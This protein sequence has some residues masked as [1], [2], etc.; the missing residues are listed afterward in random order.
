MSLKNRHTNIHTHTRSP[1]AAMPGDAETGAPRERPCLPSRLSLSRPPFVLA[2]GADSTLARHIGQEPLSA[3]CRLSI[4][5]RRAVSVKSLETCENVWSNPKLVAG[6]LSRGGSGSALSVLRLDRADDLPLLSLFTS[7]SRA[8]RYGTSLTMSRPGTDDPLRVSQATGQTMRPAR[9]VG[10]MSLTLPPPMR[11]ARPAGLM[12]LTLPLPPAHTC[13]F[14]GAVAPSPHLIIFDKLGESSGRD[15]L[16][17]DRSMPKTSGSM[18]TSSLGFANL[19]RGSSRHRLPCQTP[20]ARPTS[21]WSRGSTNLTWSLNLKKQKLRQF[22]E[23]IFQRVNIRDLQLSGNEIQ[24][25]PAEIVRLEY[26]H[27]LNLDGNKLARLPT[28]LGALDCLQVLDVTGNLIADLD[29]QLLLPKNL[30][31]VRFA[32]NLLK[33]LPD[34]LFLHTKLLQVLDCK[35]NQLVQLPACDWGKELPSLQ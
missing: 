22:P 10:L 20:D 32:G 16:L 6:R 28:E 23:F 25:I 14:L 26:L 15:A 4:A 1:T 29:A 9:P 11:L 7:P 35:G 13:V 5:R 18:E 34:N 3:P 33:T 24:E 21:S 12:S 19:N 8:G 2:F 17:S 30:L 27:V 31:Q